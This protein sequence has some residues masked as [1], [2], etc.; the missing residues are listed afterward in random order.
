MTEI[1]EDKKVISMEEI[2]ITDEFLKEFRKVFTGSI[3][4][5][6]N[7]GKATEILTNHRKKLET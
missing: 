6:V 3:V 4:I 2:K 1:T 7:Q 5:H